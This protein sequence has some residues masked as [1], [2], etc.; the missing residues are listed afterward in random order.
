MPKVRRAFAVEWMERDRWSGPEHG[1][2]TVALDPEMLSKHVK[3]YTAGRSI[4]NVPDSYTSPTTLPKQV[5][6]SEQLFKRIKKAK[7]SVLWVSK[8][9]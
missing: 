7:N 8:L 5:E 1:G 2:W 3:S 9:K 4:D 6:V